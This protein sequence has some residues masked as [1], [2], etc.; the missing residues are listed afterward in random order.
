MTKDEILAE[1]STSRAAITREY[2]VLRSELDFKTKLDNIVRRRPYLWLSG[3]AALGWVLA[4]PKKRTRV[5]TKFVKQNGTPVVVREKGKRRA[6]FI[7]L[8]L[9]VMRFTFPL[10]K[11]ALTAYAGKV[12]ADMATKFPK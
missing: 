7:A 10:V 9:G 4:G 3:A 12:F 2:G 5:V 1:L 8:L 6:G 11:P